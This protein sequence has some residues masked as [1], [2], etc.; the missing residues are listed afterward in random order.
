MSAIKVE[1]NAKQEMEKLAKRASKVGNLT[2]AHKKISI[3]LDRWVQTNMRSQGKRVGG[4][5][6]FAEVCFGGPRSPYHK[7]KVCGRGRVIGRG[8]GRKLDKSAKLL[9]DT[10]TLRKSL[11]GGV[12][13]SRN[14]AGVGSDLVY[15]KPHEE[16]KGPLPQR[17]ML[18][19]DKEVR[20]DV[21]K[22]YTAFID[23]EMRK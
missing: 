8:K 12:F 7:T 11:A 20:R 21:I 15:A 4:W 16:G 22:V 23:K 5:K 3:L 17:R 9:L 18:P 14:N 2:I 13:Y 19:T 10:G 6:P 1:T